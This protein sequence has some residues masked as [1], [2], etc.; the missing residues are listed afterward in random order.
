MRFQHPLS[1]LYPHNDRRSAFYPF[2]D[3]FPFER[4]C[5]RIVRELEK[6][7]WEV[8]GITVEFSDYGSG[9][10][11]FR[12]VD[13]IR[14][15]EFKLKFG[16]TQRGGPYGTGV[17][18]VTIPH[19]QLTVWED[20]GDPEL[21]YYVGTD[22]E[23]D[24][25]EFIDGRKHMSKLFGQPRTYLVYKGSD[26]TEE[27]FPR[28]AGNGPRSYF[29][30]DN[31]LEREYDPQGDEPKFFDTKVVTEEYK[32]YLEETVLKAITSHP[33]VRTNGISIIDALVGQPVDADGRQT[34]YK[35][36]RVTENGSKAVGA[37]LTQADAN[38]CLERYAP[39]EAERV[40][41]SDGT[42]CAGEWMTEIGH[43]TPMPK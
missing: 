24:R 9:E 3:E 23:R 8:P 2:T 4:A 21:I 18:E 42:L 39:P 30:H 6:R 40:T 16:R 22:W 35:V 14:G 27:R 13:C 26:N 31:D 33:V 5:E 36:V 19:K 28:R 38:A 15:R 17:R 32:Q 10:R 20:Y 34:Y 37:F 41:L 7:N 12:R 25:G 11:G 43:H 29:L 1:D